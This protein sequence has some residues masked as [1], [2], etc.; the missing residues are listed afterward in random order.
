MCCVPDLFMEEEAMFSLSLVKTE[1][2]RLEEMVDIFSP[3]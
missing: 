2:K 1:V 3:A